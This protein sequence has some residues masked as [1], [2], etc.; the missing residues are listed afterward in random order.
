MKLIDS[1]TRTLLAQMREQAPVSS[2]NTS[3]GALLYELYALFGSLAESTRKRSER[4]SATG[5]I[6]AGSWAVL[7]T[8]AAQS[9]EG[10]HTFA[11]LNDG[12]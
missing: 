7:Q 1:P 9:G 4:Q 5:A 12:R 8:S 3:A 11:V 10:M 2:R 6:Y